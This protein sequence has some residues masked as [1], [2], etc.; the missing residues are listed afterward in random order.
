MSSEEIPGTSLRERVERLLQERIELV[1]YD[2]TWPELFAEERQRLLQLVP[3]GLLGRIEHMGSTAIPGMLA[4]PIVDMLVEVFSAESAQDV[5]APL[6]EAQGYEYFWR[7]SFGNDVPPLY[8]WF[9]RRGADGQR[10]HHIHMVEPHFAH[11]DRLAFRDYL[12]IHPEAALEYAAL[13][14]RLV[15]E[16]AGDRVAYTQGKTAFI[17]RV[18]AQA[19]A[20]NANGK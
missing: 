8:A 18:T 20:E 17:H 1:E 5:I 4:K 14:R 6:L 10:S 13:K 3:P 12:R 16:H 2:P 19:L 15:L 11:W 9:I 7:P